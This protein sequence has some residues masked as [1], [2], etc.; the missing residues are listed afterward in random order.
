MDTNELVWDELGYLWTSYPTAAH[1]KKQLASVGVT[2]TVER[3][4][5][6]RAWYIL[7]EHGQMLHGDSL[8]RSPDTAETLKV[9]R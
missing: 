9:A 2:A 4:G 5:S 3:V 8:S 1:V 7:N 6:E